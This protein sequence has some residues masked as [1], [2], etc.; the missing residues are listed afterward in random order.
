MFEQYDEAKEIDW[1]WLNGDGYMSKAPLAQES[2]GKT[3][4]DRGKTATNAISS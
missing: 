4:T 2:A 1:A 3:P